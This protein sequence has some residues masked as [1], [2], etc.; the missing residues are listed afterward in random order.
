MM[1]KRGWEGS[2]TQQSS[3]CRTLLGCCWLGQGC[4]SGKVLVMN[5][6][7]QVRSMVG[8]GG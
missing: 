4:S 6:I 1:I 2:R 5:P 3:R 8:E 7:A